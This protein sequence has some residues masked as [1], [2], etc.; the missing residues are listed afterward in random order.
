MPFNLRLLAELLGSGVTA[1][2]LTPLRTQLDLLEKYW[3]WRVIGSDR[4]GNEREDILRNACEKMVDARALR[5]DRA[6]L[7]QTSASPQLDELLSNQVLVEW[8]S[9]PMRHPTGMF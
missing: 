6:A 3:Q 1:D 8:Q 2:D 9:S 5:L 7:T 4:H